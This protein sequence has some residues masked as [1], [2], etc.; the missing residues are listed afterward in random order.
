MM[1]PILWIFLSLP[2]MDNLTREQRRKNMQ[3]IRSVGTQPELSIMREL[4]RK[5]SI[6]QVMPNLLQENQILSLEE[7][8][9][10]C[11]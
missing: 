9:L 10:Q 1:K 11:L 6:L 8:R 7:K 5:K 3:N 4:K 2:V